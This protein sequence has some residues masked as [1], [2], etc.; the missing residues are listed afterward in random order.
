[1]AELAIKR[2]YEPADDGDGKRI[3]V[4]RIW[5]RGVSKDEAR[6]DLWLKDVA[7]T[8][9]L[10]QWFGH[11]PARWTEFQARYR[12]ELAANPA[13]AT[14]R[15]AATGQK[16]TLL[17]GAHDPDHNQAVVLYDVLTSRR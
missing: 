1:M 15:A 16:T 2:I 11:D 6:L 7:P 3:L 5:P 8:T 17:Y 13:L 4:D 14:L 12:A 9:A 10:R